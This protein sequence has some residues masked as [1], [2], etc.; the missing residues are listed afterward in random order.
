MAGK[1]GFGSAL[2]LLLAAGLGVSAALTP[3]AATTRLSGDWHSTPAVTLAKS[4][5]PARPDAVDNGEAPA[6]ARLGRM[7]L[8][9][10]PSAAQQQAL[11]QELAALQNP[12][13]PQYHHW[14]T[15]TAF[16]DAYGNSAADVAAVAAWLSSQGLQ[17]APLPQGRGWIEFSGTVAQVEQAFQA[18][19]HAYATVQGTRYAL[20]GPISIPGALA[21]VVKG[22]V[23]LD[24]SLA[25]P[26][27][28]S[29][30]P[31]AVPVEQLAAQTTLGGAP[32]LTPRLAAQI[33]HL[34]SLQANGVKGAGETIAIAS[35]SNIDVV[36]VDAFRSVFGLPASALSVA[37]QGT[38]PGLTDGQAEATLEASWA[39]AA[40]PAARVL[41]APAATT[42][43]TDGIDLS[44]AAI[45]DQD[46]APIVAM[47][48][49]DC[50][51]AL[52][53]AHQAFYAAL[54][55]QAA[56]EGISVIAAAGD[57]G[58]AAC[59][60]AGND[61][62][63]SSGYGVNAL[64]STPWNTAVG[65]AS[66]GTTGP[67]GAN[68]ALAAWSPVNAADAAYAGGGGV[69]SL[70][71]VPG[72]QP[73]QPALT[74]TQNR[75]MPDLSLPTAIDTSAD[76]GL[77]FCLGGSA[78]CTLVRSGGSAGAAALFAGIAALVAQQ[79]GAQGNMTPTLYA[80]S[81][82]S[83]VYS[84]VQQGAA[85]LSCAAG[86]PGCGVS[87]KIGYPAATGYDLA[88]GLG[89]VNAQ[90]LVHGWAQPEANGTQAVTVTNTI[91]PSQTINPS[92][93]VVLSATVT[94]QTSSGAP[95]GTVTFYDQFTA[96]S[97]TTV[98]LTVGTGGSQ[99]ST[100]SVTVTG[101]LSQGG[102]PIVAQYS[103]DTTYAA[104]SS[105]PVVVQVQPSPTV[106]VVTPVS[107]NPAPGSSLTVTATITS[108]N[109]GAGALA[110][111]GTV[112]F[113][114]DGVSQGIKAVVPG[115]PAAP[116]TNS[117][118][119][120]TFTVPYSAGTHQ[121]VGFYSGDTN[122]NN[123][124]SAAA[125]ITVST[126][127]PTVTLTP[128]TTTPAA[129]SSL[130][131]TMTI[132]PPGSTTTPPTGTVTVTMD[133]ANVGTA[134]VVSGSPSSTATLNITAPAIGTH[135]LQ[136]TY[137]GDANFST[138]TSTAV[139]IT[140][141]KANT[142]LTLTPATT[143][144]TGGSS[145]LLTATLAPVGATPSTPTGT[146]TFTLDGVSQGTATLT[147]GTTATLTINAPTSGSHTVQA[148]YSGDT[149][150]QSSISSAVTLNVAK[151]STTTV[152]TPVS[153]TVALG[154]AQS[155]TVDI[156]PATAGAS[157]P[158]GTVSFTVDGVAAGT[159]TVIPGSPST[160][161][162]SI[163]FSTVGTHS[164]R[165][166]YSGDTNYA[167]STSSPISVSVAKG[168]PT[169][170]AT[171]GTASPTAGS[172]LQLTAS[173]APGTT[174][175][176]S[177]TGTVIFQIDG[178][179]VGTGVVVSGNPA[180]S[181]ITITAPSVGSHT[182]Q[183]VY[184]GDSN[185][186]T[187][188]STATVFTVAKS[189]TTLAL[190]P[191]TTTP[192]GGSSLLLTATLSAPGTATTQPTGSIIFTMD[193]ASVGSASLASGTTATLTITA[194]TSGTHT[195]QASYV[196][197]NNYSAATSPAVTINV[198]KNPTTLT[199]TPSTTTPALGSTV[200]V[201]ATI[202]AASP[203]STQPSGSVTFTLDGA[204]VGV[205]PVLPGSPST[206]SITLPAMTPG[207]HILAASYSGDTYYATATATAVS[208][209]VP[210]SPTST[211]ITPAT[212]SSSGGS[213]LQV[214]ATVIA[215]NP[216][217]S[218][219]TG[220]VN[221]SVDGASAGVSALSPG[222]P[223]TTT[224]NLAA[225]TPG[226]HVIIG[227]Y[228]GDTYYGTSSSTPVTVSVSKSSTTTTLTPSTI[229]PT[230]GGSMSVTVSISSPNP[231]SA[232]PGGTVTITMDGATVGTG[233]VTAGV[234]SLAVVTI[235]VVSAGSHL[236][237]AVYS[238]DTYYTGSN[239]ST[240]SIVAAK[241]ASTTTVT[242]SPA[243][244]TVGKTETL[245]AAIA[246]LSPSTGV[247]YTFTG[248]VSFY[249]GGTKL[250]GTVP[251]SANAA[252]LTGVSLANNVNHTITA[253]YS[254]DIN[255]LGSTSGP[256]PLAAST[257]P[258]TVVLT[259][260][261]TTAP[262]GA[263]IVLTATVTPTMTPDPTTGE[264][265]PTGNVVF[266][267]GTTV[268][269]IA[270]LT[271]VTPGD[272]SVATLTTQTL[273][274]GQDAISAY[275]QGDLFYD[276]ATSNILTLTVQ[277]FT[278]T[279]ASGNPPTNLNIVQGSAGSA[280]FVITGLGGYN[281]LVQIVC[282]VPTQD[283]MT[284]T[285]SPQQ[286]TPP[287]TVTFVVQTYKSGAPGTTAANHE[288]A[289]PPW[290]RKAGGAALALL[291]FVL[292]PFGWRSR[293]RLLGQARCVLIL[294]LL[295]AGLAGA[296]IGCTSNNALPTSAITGTPLG[297]ATLKVVGTA[298]VN[299]TVV[300]RSAYFTVNVIAPGT[301]AP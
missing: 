291:C 124:T 213:S 18:Q 72:W 230:A 97:I 144:P 155:I 299:N 261:Y 270:A 60:A 122:Y 75:L 68:S 13:S 58:A 96:T 138:A 129:G 283:N 143:T 202:A 9:L 158:S 210:K 269:G 236:L 151:T 256:L 20:A 252:V 99:S 48:Y 275:Y 284:C 39:G 228:S 70:Y 8:L 240:V 217:T 295:L 181:T 51:A 281:N 266:Y 73:I 157:T 192:V 274:G 88:T 184:S 117:T 111:S 76:P 180:T 11:T 106:T 265:N 205:S 87:G 290:S 84:D 248:S 182:L 59:H 211:A 212:T 7:L 5:A 278:L 224:I 215:T 190:T 188:T 196:G 94:S 249:D 36:D 136:A 37:P 134:P 187:A 148:S 259:S 251:V 120:I 43:A 126:S 166:I 194:P 112:D 183:V 17:V 174:G 199:I 243:S 177:P 10:Q 15:P 31:V 141:A 168:T 288:G 152:I 244:L 47:G 162:G 164:V 242:A 57:S 218:F 146:V 193:G 258:D 41:L 176:T 254:G 245:T 55:R 64:A 293:R 179:A 204:T 285:A 298:Y 104:A 135:T 241:G 167:T 118:S 246:P 273:P 286:V 45:V 300:N 301:T 234:P 272:S 147:S 253:V 277:D 46:L 67:A 216:G 123:S 159:A 116:S 233:T 81:S 223:S 214:S 237:Q 12:A 133:G 137:N 262:P 35:T 287:A 115:V 160:A 206:A 98:P 105:Q 271:P 186:N 44:L 125:A 102:H 292:L 63:V 173:I 247:T 279:A 6:G 2:A 263:A 83:G 56:A 280:S 52:S 82:H 297:V 161:T 191:A 127:T 54:Y 207:T 294:A 250:L 165:A 178:T 3:Q 219:P 209:T 14:L 235:P 79:N 23:S 28:A 171:T 227:T 32:A 95:T 16:A 289:V 119:S 108:S 163:T 170:T 208:L 66:F 89:M 153:G 61:A 150:F 232:Q 128:A 93:S 185:Y 1:R 140:V 62:P 19:V 109:A 50:E 29:P 69:S 222:S 38:D 189:T 86:S 197:D 200:P 71:R 107:T 85:Q 229:T 77:A 131:L 110:P 142:T 40:A 30:Q 139:S 121:I 149:N 33:L 80:L 101:V 92:G 156:T 53:P 231:A 175:A 238:G 268:L 201:T 203:G 172:S 74:S 100:A 114:L 22:L 220:T 169:V 132:T 239:S 4:G 26:A 225:L 255:W 267:N 91:L 282:Q 78:G 103:G 25:Q 276:V 24:G 221:F 260:N 130:A 154:A 264:A 90:A 49:S 113:R 65:V 145:L 195:L 34:D 226:S 296:G 21:P 27:L 257:L 198:A 42:A